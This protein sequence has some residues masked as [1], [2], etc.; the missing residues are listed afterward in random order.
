MTLQELY[1]QH[2]EWRDHTLVVSRDNC[3]WYD[4]I[5]E[6]GLVY[7]PERDEEEEG[8]PLLVFTSKDRLF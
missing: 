3:D 6:S 5:G 7:T 4:Y 8:P 2:P 1:D